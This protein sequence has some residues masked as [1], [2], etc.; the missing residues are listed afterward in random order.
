MDFFGP[1]SYNRKILLKV[2]FDKT[3]F[4]KFNQNNDEKQSKQQK[5][6][7]KSIPAN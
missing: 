7:R 6:H 5:I 3:K 2:V 4:V 1:P